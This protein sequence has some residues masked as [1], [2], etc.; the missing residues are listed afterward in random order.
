MKRMIT[1]Y[2]VFL[3][4]LAPTILLSPSTS[5]AENAE[6]VNFVGT[7]DNSWSD[8]AGANLGYG[9][10]YGAVRA[11]ISPPEVHAA[12]AMWRVHGSGQWREPHQIHSLRP[13]RHTIE[14]K[15][16]L[17]W[18]KPDNQQVFVHQGLVSTV[19]GLYTIP[20]G[21]RVML[22]PPQALQ[23]GAAWRK[24]GT[25]TWRS[26]GFMERLAPG[27]HEIE[28]KSID[29]WRKPPNRQLCVLRNQ[30][31]TFFGVY[32]IPQ[33]LRM[34]IHPAQ[35]RQAG[36]W[37]K[38][39]TQTW[40]PHGFME[41]LAPGVHEIEFKSIDGWRR[42]PNRSIV[43]LSN[44]MTTAHALYSPVNS[45]SLPRTGQA[46]SHRPGDDGDLKTGVAWPTPRFTDN[47]NGTVTDNLTN[48][49][50]LK[51]ADCFGKKN[52]TDAVTEA[53]H[54]ENGRCG[55]RDGSRA[56][57]WWLPNVVQIQSLINWGAA[58][59]PNWLLTQGFVNVRSSDHY[60]SGTTEAR[61]PSA[62]WAPS[63]YGYMRNVAKIEN[64]FHV[65]PVRNSN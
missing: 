9:Y 15:S 63:L 42:L 3:V 62:A 56:G 5:S 53:R 14:F 1:M 37:R 46:S 30:M 13:G 49:V 21:L 45:I 43:V 17:N 23:A 33:G 24:V 61:L 59:P 47:R 20:Q 51:N 58:D 35:A 40:R 10:G 6:S 55:L 2:A 64:E 60:W 57:D 34:M 52:W 8:T 48:L 27:T 7:I 18:N 11:M 50:W 16:I 65:W 39:G 44:Q 31:N 19:S 32:T 22:D 4:L 26:H 25:Q 28:F 36:A 12:G 38:A 41:R 54:L 29:D